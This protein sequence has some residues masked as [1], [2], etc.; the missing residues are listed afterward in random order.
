MTEPTTDSGP[1]PL[2]R[3]T[4]MPPLPRD[5]AR[6]I[7]EGKGRDPSSFSNPLGVPIPGKSKGL[8]AYRVLRPLGGGGMGVVYLAD[9]IAPVKRRVALKLIKVGMDTRDVVARFNSERQA[10]ALMSHPNIAHVY[11]AGTTETGRPYFAMEY[12]PGWPITEYCDTRKLPVAER[13]RIFQRV[14]D[15]VAHAHQ[16]GIIHRDLKPSNI[17]VK[18]LGEHAVPKIIDFG[19][20]KAINRRLVQTT[21]FTEAGRILGTPEYMSPEQADDAGLALDPRSDIYTLG[22]I[23]YELLAGA[24]PFQVTELQRNP[25]REIRRQICEDDPP[26]PSAQLTPLGALA[27]M[28]ARRRRTSPSGLSR[29]LSGDLDWIVM[30]ALEKDRTRRYRTASELAD[31]LDRYLRHEPILAG[32]PNASYL[33]RKFLKKHRGKVAAGLL[34]GLAFAIGV[35]IGASLSEGSPTGV[36]APREETSHERESPPPELTWKDGRVTPG[37]DAAPAVPAWRDIPVRRGRTWGSPPRLPERREEGVSPRSPPDPARRILHPAPTR[38]PLR[39]L[40]ETALVLDRAGYP[41][42]AERILRGTLEGCYCNLGPFHD[43]TVEAM[44]NLG[45][46]LVSWGRMEEGTPLLQDAATLRALVH[47][48]KE[49]THLR[50]NSRSPQ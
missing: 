46:W 48:G 9:Q 24:L 16:Q 10:L 11:D 45:L 43:D 19:V 50:T 2:S 30:K 25:V 7:R 15:A 12:V 6:M 22:V 32:P 23:L 27:G 44:E 4:T 40:R 47:E 38:T 29:I 39:Q 28:I 35:I 21:V 1:R 31:D 49:G 14:C 8:G 18:D 34:V 20:A 36:A 41:G 5:V 13:I 26:R 37:S 17:L 42:E 33:V 3:R